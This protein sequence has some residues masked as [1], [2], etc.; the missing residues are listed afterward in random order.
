MH[1]GIAVSDLVGDPLMRPS[2]QV[3]D[4]L[5]AAVEAIRPL[6]VVVPG[7]GHEPLILV[8]VLELDVQVRHAL[9]DLEELDLAVDSAMVGLDRLGLDGARHDVDDVAHRRHL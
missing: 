4:Q 9:L 5:V 1:D 6:V 2:P 8:P 7:H 3:D